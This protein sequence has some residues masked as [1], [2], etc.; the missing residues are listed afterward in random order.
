[1]THPLINCD[2]YKIGHYNM[3]P[4][5]TSKVYSNLTARKR[6]KDNVW[7]WRPLYDANTPDRRSPRLA[8]SDAIQKSADL[9]IECVPNIRLGERVD[10][11][12]FS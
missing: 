2:F 10:K 1:M 5:G 3:Y 4:K 7:T 12:F 11:E 6:L 8:L 9:E